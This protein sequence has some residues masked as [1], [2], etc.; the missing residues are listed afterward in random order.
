MR[1][2]KA[3]YQRVIS[4]VMGFLCKYIC[5]HVPFSIKKWHLFPTFPEVG[6]KLEN[7]FEIQVYIL[8][9]ILFEVHER[10][11]KQG[12]VGTVQYS[13]TTG[14]TKEA[15]HCVRMWGSTRSKTMLDDLGSA[16]FPWATYL[17]HC[18][19]RIPQHT[20]ESDP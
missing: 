18:S 20:P 14:R 8:K 10:P 9:E 16:G 5:F 6:S 2:R 17:D 3:P 15:K 19:C 13:L 1:T 7:V 11:T 12:D 4:V